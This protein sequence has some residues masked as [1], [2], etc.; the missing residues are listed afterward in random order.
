LTNDWIV[1]VGCR[2]R[3]TS[4]TG[5]ADQ[6]LVYVD[7][8]APPHPR[9]TTPTTTPTSGVDVA[10]AENPEVVPTKSMRRRKQSSEQGVARR[11]RLR[12]QRRRRRRKRLE[13]R[14]KRRGS[15]S[16][17]EELSK[18]SEEQSAWVWSGQSVRTTI[19]RAGFGPSTVQQKCGG[20]HKNFFRPFHR[21]ESAFT[22]LK[23]SSS[24]LV[25]PFLCGSCSSE[26]AEHALNPPPATASIDRKRQPQ[27]KCKNVKW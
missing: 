19:A 1:W 7:I 11:R 6:R 27:E 25:W 9:V 3:V 2:F 12:K 18:L 14:L 15:A 22:S 5:D 17:T 16:S 4:P 13:R 23:K 24:L 20:C 21:K 10:A 26:H 8:S